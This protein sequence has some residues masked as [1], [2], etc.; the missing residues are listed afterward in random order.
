MHKNLARTVRF[1]LK[2][3]LRELRSDRVSLPHCHDKLDRIKMSVGITDTSSPRNARLQYLPSSLSANE[4]LESH[5]YNR[6]SWQMSW[7]G[8]SLFG[9]V[10]LLEQ[11]R[12]QKLVGLGALAGETSHCEGADP[13]RSGALD[14]VPGNS[15]RLCSNFVWTF[16]GKEFGFVLKFGTPRWKYKTQKFALCRPIFWATSAYFVCK[17]LKKSTEKASWGCFNRSVWR[18]PSKKTCVHQYSTSWV[19]DERLPSFLSCVCLLHLY[20]IYSYLSVDQQDGHEDGPDAAV[21]QSADDGDANV[22]GGG[23]G[24]AVPA[25][26]GADAESRRRRYRHRHVTRAPV[27]TRGGGIAEADLTGLC[28]SEICE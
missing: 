17:T 26:G 20:Y 13:R 19:S 14:L 10:L 22:S 16:I 9:Q 28:G 12:H 5:F 27:L 8:P 11:K 21:A 25:A 23:G 7:R 6:L 15:I 4:T 18:K 2:I 3:A 24:A 1:K